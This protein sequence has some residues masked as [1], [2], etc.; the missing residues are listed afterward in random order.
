MYWNRI[1]LLFNN[2]LADITENCV[3]PIALLLRNI[4]FFL[5]LL[6]YKFVLRYY[7]LKRKWRKVL[8]SIL[9]Q[10]I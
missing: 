6:T 5:S 3:V 7:L 8:H 4:D 9:L 2:C 1:K 10:G